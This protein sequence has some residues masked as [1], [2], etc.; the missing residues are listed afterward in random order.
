ME[1]QNG[2]GYE[3]LR[4]LADFE[5]DSINTGQIWQR[6]GHAA[7]PTQRVDEKLLSDLKSLDSLLQAGGVTREA[8]HAPKGVAACAASGHCRQAKELPEVSWNRMQRRY[9]V[10]PVV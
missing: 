10:F 2:C 7:D 6:W 1:F 5:A 8:S 4:K 9:F 3:V